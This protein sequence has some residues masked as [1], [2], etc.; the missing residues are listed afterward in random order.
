MQNRDIDTIES[1]PLST[2]QFRG[3]NENKAID[4][5]LKINAAHDIIVNATQ[6]YIERALPSS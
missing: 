4:N 6:E 2:G 3:S 5:S 1:Y